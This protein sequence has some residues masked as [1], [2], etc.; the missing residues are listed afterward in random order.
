[1]IPNYFILVFIHVH[2]INHFG[3][4]GAYFVIHWGTFSRPFRPVTYELKIETKQINVMNA[5]AVEK[6]DLDDFKY[7]TS[8]E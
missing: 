3:K 1:M 8:T 2:E 5:S 7:A 6:L 4:F